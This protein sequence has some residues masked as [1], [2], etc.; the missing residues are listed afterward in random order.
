M[1]ENEDLKSKIQLFQVQQ[2]LQ[3][4]FTHSHLTMLSL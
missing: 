3:R 2:R 1:N 4:L